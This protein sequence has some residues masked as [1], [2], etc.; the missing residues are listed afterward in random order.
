MDKQRQLYLKQKQ[1]EFLEHQKQVEF[2]MHQFWSPHSGQAPVAFNLFREWKR[3]V[4]T[5]CGRKWGKT[6]FVLYCLYLYAML[7]PNSQIY[8]IADTMKHA[9]ELVWENG[10]LQRFFLSTKRKTNESNEEYQYRRQIGRELNDKWIAKTNNSEM[11]VTLTNN[12]FIKVDGAENYKNADGI[13]PDFIAYDEFKHH[14]PR[15]NEAMEPNLRVKRAPLLIVGTPPEELD[16]YYEKI[17]N[18]VKRSPYGYFCRRPS[19][20]NPYIYPL[21]EKD[22]DFQEEIEKYTR[23]GEEDVLQREL[24][25]KIVVSGSRAIFPM[26]EMPEFNYEI[27]DYEGYSKHIRPHEELMKIIRHKPK[28]WEW[29]GAY[30]PAGSSV[31]AGL[32]GALNKHTKEVYLLGEIYETDQYDMTATKIYSKGQKIRTDLHP[33]DSYWDQCYDNQASWFYNEVINAFPDDEANLSPCDKDTNNK[34]NKL[35][36]IKDMLLNEKLFIS[37][38]LKKMVWEMINYRKDDKGKI[39]KENDHL[40]DCLRYM[41]NQMM[42]DPTFVEK[43]VEIEDRRGY[44]IDEDIRQFAR[45][46]AGFLPRETY[47]E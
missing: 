34:E 37:A 35:S 28:D 29:Y 25:A 9:G 12:S 23:R 43:K 15:Y 24:Y 18:S 33:M 45:Q 44:S 5:Q 27:D 6:D 39:P 46:A 41:L 16:T 30:D 13:E 40:L 21:G 36:L 4:F 26:L 20:M 10:R 32:F 8:Y 19:F 38:R 2:E 22:P 3:Y 7:F 17:A 31:F 1:S 14:D 42:Y 47:E 11:R